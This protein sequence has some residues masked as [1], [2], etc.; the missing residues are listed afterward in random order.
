MYA[1][2]IC[3]ILVFAAD[4]C[5]ILSMPQS[6]EYASV[7]PQISVAYTS[8]TCVSS[9]EN[10]RNQMIISYKYFTTTEDII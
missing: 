5:G 4:I 9:F 7:M 2:N 6:N 3:S 1:T 10:G 8:M